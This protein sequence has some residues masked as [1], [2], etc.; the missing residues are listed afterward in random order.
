MSDGGKTAERRAEVKAR[1]REAMIAAVADR[2]FSE[3][4]V[5]DLAERAG[6][7]R[8]GFYFYYDDKREL[9]MESA[10]AAT[11]TLFRQ[12]D[13][14]WH[15]DGEP[16][17]LVR[18]ALDGVATAWWANRRVL[19]TAVEVST[20]DPEMAAYWQG[21]VNRFVRATSEHIAREQA[22]GAI[23]DRLDPDNAAGVLIWG[24]ERV[25][26]VHTADGDRSGLARQVQALRHVWLRAM[27]GQG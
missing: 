19:R 12:A 1:L 27:Y 6:L 23:D 26:Y 7:S 16:A 4:R 13:A 8:S 5:A 9:L 25:L 21:L 20:Y 3:L 10:A 22:T 17:E 18:E 11:D 15:G 2:P 14:W 24:A